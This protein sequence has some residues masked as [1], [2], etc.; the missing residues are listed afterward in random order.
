M[1]LVESLLILPAHLA[2]S[3]PPSQRG[4]FGW[5]N[6]QQQ[7]FSRGLEWVVERL[8]VPLLVRAVRHRFVTVAVAAGLLIAA[9]GLVAGGRVGFVF[10]PKVEGD[11][12]TATVELSHGTSATDTRVVRDRIQAAADQVIAELGDADDVRGAFAQL[13]AISVFGQA[14][15]MGTARGSH[16]TEVAVFFVPLSQRSFTTTEF[17][18]QWRDAVGHV[19]GSESVRFLFDTRS[20]A[21]A[22][23]HLD[24]SHPDPSSLRAA[25]AEL[26]E[27]IAGYPGVFD[28]ND[29]FAR[30]KDQ[31][32]LKLKPAAKRLG[33]TERAVARQVRAAF[34]GS[35]A[36]R[37][38][39]GRDELRVYVRYPAQQRASELAVENLIVRAPEGGEI[40]L[41]AVARVVHG[42][43]DPKIRHR[44]GKQ[45]TSVTADVDEAVG[46]AASVTARIL[47]QQ[48]PDLQRAYPGLTFELGGEQQT[49]REILGGLGQ[50]YLIALVA[51]FAL[52]AIAFRSYV[53]PLIVMTAIPFGLV[54]AVL[55]HFIMG[56]EF[57]VLGLLGIVALSGVVIN[58][59]LILTVAINRYRDM[60]FSTADAIELG[61]R[62][63]FRPILL[64]SLTTF[65]GL[66]PMLL[67][68]SV[69]ARFLIPMAVSLAFGIIAATALLLVLV[70]AL[71]M[72]LDDATRLFARVRPESVPKAVQV[73]P[74]SGEELLGVTDRF[75]RERLLGRRP[76]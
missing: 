22:P 55:G 3:K 14:G 64:T 48:I 71:Y 31:I 68:T 46:N 20:N 57:S 10:F 34:F 5:I 8:Y 70:P 23:I 33:L 35:E 19:P 65:F 32:E 9:V 30:G 43:A 58:D 25:A 11:I 66:A 29:G 49:Q 53:Q 75:M 15:E 51:I 74:S 36:A 52:L 72:I 67:E 73:E 16:L 69:Q 42:N 6:R 24:L 59:S 18:Q 40:P 47:D 76:S 7:R 1:S 21:E 28:V 27:R 26:A 2:H 13:G 41:A 61:G 44:G 39:R 50:G 17:M 60:G 12:I 56:Y 62:R 54:G 45:I 63:R 38:Q 37:V 4:V